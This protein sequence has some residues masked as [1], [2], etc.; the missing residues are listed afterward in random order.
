MKIKIIDKGGYHFGGTLKLPIV[1]EAVE[2]GV[3][4]EVKGSELIKHGADDVMID[5]D[6]EYRFNHNEVEVVPV[7]H[8]KA[9]RQ[10]DQMQCVCG[11]AWDIDDTDLPECR[12]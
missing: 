3:S 2:F 4:F 1:V 8:C 9:I 7:T 6:Y 11:L 12:A 10:G 5:P